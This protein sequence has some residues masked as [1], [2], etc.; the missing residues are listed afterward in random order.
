MGLSLETTH[1]PVGIAS[2]QLCMGSSLETSPA[3][4]AN[5]QRCVKGHAI[6][7]EYIRRTQ[8]DE[9]G[10]QKAG[11]RVHQELSKPQAIL[12]DYSGAR[13]LH[14]TDAL[15]CTRGSWPPTRKPLTN[16]K[17]SHEGSGLLSGTQ[18]KGT[19]GNAHKPLFGP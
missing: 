1:E 5:P 13:G 19:Q 3:L 7:W 11:L 8:D 16:S 6:N 15:A 12:M 18:E 14:H 4:A 9:R 10:W 2:G 17:E